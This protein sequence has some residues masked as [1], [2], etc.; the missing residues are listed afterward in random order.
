MQKLPQSVP[1]LAQLLGM[2]PTELR[3][4]SSR[5]RTFVSTWPKRKRISGVR[6]ITEPQAELMELLRMISAKVLSQYPLH[7]FVFHRTGS[8]YLSL[9]RTVKGN[10]FILTADIDDFYPTVSP[11][12]VYI[13]LV[14]KGIG[15]EAAKCLTKLTTHKYQ[16][17]QGFP[18]SPILAATVIEPALNRLEGFAKAYDVMVGIYADNLVIGGKY[19][20][21]NRLHLIKKIFDNYGFE[22]AKFKAMGNETTREIMN[23]ELAHGKL[24]VKTGYI[25]EVRENID[26]VSRDGPTHLGYEEQMRSIQGKINFINDVNPHQAD[27]LSR[28]LKKV[29]IPS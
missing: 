6:I 19:D 7:H 1:E 10:S 20:F 8:S 24:K 18:T 11:H 22:I 14:K 29:E 15:H 28:Y 12:K 27:Q 5:M 13:A 16:L 4:F 25:Q 9:I 26:Q 23:I 21:S 2:A 3:F 17:P